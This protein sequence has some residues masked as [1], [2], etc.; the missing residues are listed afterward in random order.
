MFYY[1]V[2]IGDLRYHGKTA[3]T[4]S[5][6]VELL[7]GSVVRIALRDRSVLGVVSKTVPE[8]SFAAK[9]IAAI[10][11][12]APMPSQALDLIQWFQEYYP[13]PFG[14]IIRQFLPP[15]VAFPQKTNTPAKAVQA[16]PAVQLPPLTSEQH[17]AVSAVANSGYHLLH[18]ITGSGKTRVYIE[19]VQRTLAAGKSAIV[20]TPEIGLTAQLHDSLAQAFPSKIRTLHS[21]M[22]GATRRNVWYEILNDSKPLVV[23]GPRSALFAPVQKLGLIV[24]DESHDQAYKSETAPYYRTERVAAKLAELH[25]ACLISGSATPSVEEYYVAAAKGRPKIQLQH[26]AISSGQPVES[27]MVDMRDRSQ[28]S[29]SQILSS[30]LVKTIG[31]ALQS[32]SQSLLFLNR[33]GTAGTVLCQQC[34][35]RAICEYCDLALTYHGDSHHMQCHVCGRSSRLPS[36]C[37]ECQ[38]AD[39]VLKTVGTKAVV[40][41]ILRLFPEANVQRFDTDTDKADQLERHLA[42]IKDGSADIIIGTQMVTKGLDLPKLAVVGVLNADASLLIPDYSA[43]ERTFQMLTQVIGR[44]GRGHQAGHVVI[45]TYDPDSSL[46]AAAITNVNGCTINGDTTG[47]LTGVDPIL[48]PLQNN[49]GSTLTQAL[50]A[51][52]PAINTGN[53]GGC[54]DHNSAILNTDQRG[55]TRPA[56]G[57]SLCD[58]GAY[59]AGAVDAPTPTP[60]AT[61]VPTI[62]FTPDHWTYLP[63]IEK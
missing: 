39:V 55:F 46:L 21:R 12:S 5:S 54:R 48:G 13:A 37:P 45:Q 44:T 53:P 61:L 8:P 60:T 35:W 50:L 18:G 1:E 16:V 24:I 11:P 17:T 57:S 52:S 2:L 25:D 43:T 33:R 63:L 26:L 9:P 15:I 41:D 4:Y 28:F 3:L 62:V 31:D 27:T 38:S 29:R 14:S 49:G 34:G 36:A 23:I 51:G 58:I 40:D 32:G 6:D 7:P 42:A 30:P 56:S 59:E 19:L 10:A 47:N 20:L 22:T